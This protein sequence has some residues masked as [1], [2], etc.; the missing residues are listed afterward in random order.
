MAYIN[1]DEVYILDNTGLQVD[2][3]T[4][5]PFADAG[6]SDD[7]K[8]QARKNIAAGGTNPNLL[9]N[10]W[11]GSGEVINQ[12]GVTSSDGTGGYK[13]DRWQFGSSL[14]WT[15]SANGISFSTSSNGYA[16]CYFPEVTRFNGKT[17]TMSM[18]LSDGTI[19]SGT[20]TRTNGTSQLPISANINGADVSVGL[21]SDNSFRVRI[22]SG[23]TVSIR[24]VKLELGTVSTLAN[25]VPPDYGT[26]LLKCRRYFIRIYGHMSAYG[27][28]Y[29]GNATTAYVFLPHNQL[30]TTPT[31]SSNGVGS[32][33]LKGNGNSLA[34]T[35]VSLSSTGENGTAIIVNTSGGL[36]TNIAYVFTGTSATAYIDLSADL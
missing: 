26:E 29:A 20:I 25:D 8:A 19:Y 6:F 17:L 10:P 23:G 5:I 16:L 27:A 1:V 13:I 30:R 3:A 18:M 34:V 14:V 4:D 24:A 21:Y 11:W 12:R 31:L 9:D 33:R 35:G 2:M 36:D 32:F 7:Q 22:Y 28:G 15:L